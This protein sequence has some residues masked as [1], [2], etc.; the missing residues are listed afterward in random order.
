MRQLQIK[1]K[2]TDLFLRLFYTDKFRLSIQI[3]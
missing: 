1:R 2:N 3:K